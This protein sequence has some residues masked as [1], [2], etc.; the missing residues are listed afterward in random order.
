M[1]SFP[2]YRQPDSVD[3]GPTCLRML[4]KYYGKS[5]SLQ[6]LREHS[7]ISR[8]GVTMLG[9]SDAAECI[10]FKTLG[11]RITLDQLADAM[12]LPCVLHWN[13]NHFVVCYDVKG[14]GDKRN[15][16]SNLWECDI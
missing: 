7:F 2:V 15:R 5:Y 10:G 4:A 9:L 16:V 8:E 6:Y 12:T 1:R 14:R 13:Q 11:A 3:C